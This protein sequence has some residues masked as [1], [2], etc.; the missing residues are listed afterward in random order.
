MRTSLLMFVAALSALT[1]T[2]CTTVSENDYRLGQ[3]A[4]AESPSIK[5]EIVADC[6]A[7]RRSES[8]NEQRTYAALMNVS[9]ANYP[10]TFCKRVINAVSSGRLTYA[11][12][13]RLDSSSADQSKIIRIIQGK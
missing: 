4:L 3:T 2:G 11:D 8:L 6:V 7:E 5:R 12:I 10:T 13:A 9:V 1:L